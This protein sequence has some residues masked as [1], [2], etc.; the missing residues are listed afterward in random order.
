[1]W[2]VFGVDCRPSVIDKW[3]FLRAERGGIFSM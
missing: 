3:R 1:M 2:I